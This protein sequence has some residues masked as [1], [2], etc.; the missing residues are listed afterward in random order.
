LNWAFFNGML[1]DIPQQ[2]QVFILSLLFFTPYLYT[3]SILN[4]FLADN[5]REEINVRLVKGG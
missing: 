2:F 1:C 4:L 5:R 3:L